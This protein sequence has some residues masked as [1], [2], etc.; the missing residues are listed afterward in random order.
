MAHVARG[1]AHTVSKSTLISR[2]QDPNASSFEV[3]DVVQRMRREGLLRET[4]DYSTSI[5]ALGRK[6]HWALAH[7]L[8]QQMRKSQVRPDAASF[9][10]AVRACEKAK[11]P[12]RVLA[13]LN[14]M[15]YQGFDP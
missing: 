10:A 9:N 2:L 1:D 11:Q 8:M 13:L 6:G 12:D 4:K 7:T 3:V 5:S 14:E 15:R